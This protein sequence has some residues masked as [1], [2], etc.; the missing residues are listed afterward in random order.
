MQHG[1]ELAWRCLAAVR[2][3]RPL[4]HNITNYVAM[5]VSANLLLAVGASPAMIHA[6][7]EAAE[8]AGIADALV[9]NI[10]TLEPAWVVAM[11]AAAKVAA[12][13]GKPWVLD[14]V[15]CGA[16]AYRTGVARDLAA[17]RPT[18]I[19]GNASEI[20]ALAGADARPQG[21]DSTAGSQ[22]ARADAR[23]LAGRLGTTVAVTGA[24][25]LVTDG[26]RLIEVAN[27]DPLMTAVTALGCALSAIVG[28]FL[29][30]HADP[31]EATAAALAVYGLAGERAAAGAAGPGSLRLRLADAL[32]TMDE[33]TLLAGVRLARVD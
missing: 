25:D 16:T 32:W 24:T 18:V 4:V 27:G 1:G 13:R 8:F 26:T 30:V 7:E 19:R 22:A 33:A 6:E 2:A 23:D 10:G 29:V 11:A 9:L 5:D 17:L 28:A 31:L 14:P 3:R 21:V 20:L 12:A 15:G